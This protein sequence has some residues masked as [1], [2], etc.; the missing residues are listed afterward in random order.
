MK[1][2]IGLL[3]SLMILSTPF[4][5]QA[6]SVYGLKGNYGVPKTKPH[7]TGL[8]FFLLLTNISGKNLY[9][10]KITAQNGQKI[11]L[12]NNLEVMKNNYS[13][14]FL[15]FLGRSRSKVLDNA[16]NKALVA[17]SSLGLTNNGATVTDETQAST[18]ILN[19][20]ETLSGKNVLIN[21]EKK[22]NRNT[23]GVMDQLGLLAGEHNIVRRIGKNMRLSDGFKACLTAKQPIDK[24]RALNPV[25]IRQTLSESGYLKPRGTTAS[26]PSAGG[27][28]PPSVYGY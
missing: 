13:P 10:Q 25:L 20:F 24:I 3:I 22:L 16:A 5:P 11:S 1:K 9:D 14:K 27:H 26:S 6:H 18:I 23:L 2:I 19:Q 17:R 7:Y 12:K 28:L 8:C 21:Y 4:N 15:K